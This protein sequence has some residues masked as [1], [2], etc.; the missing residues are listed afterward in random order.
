MAMDCYSGYGTC[1][2]KKRRRSCY[3]E[4]CEA[5]VLNGRTAKDELDVW[6]DAH[7]I[8]LKKIDGLTAKLAAVKK[9]L[10]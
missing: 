6:K 4:S 1:G 2:Y 5:V 7:K 10:E 3:C 8:A 9:A